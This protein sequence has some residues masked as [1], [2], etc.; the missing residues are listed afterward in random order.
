MGAAGFFVPSFLTRLP[1]LQLRKVEISGNYSVPFEE[2]KVAVEELSKNLLKL[3]E[4]E[5]ENLLNTR[6]GN[7]IREV[8]LKRSFT[9]EG[10][11]LKVAVEER[12]PVARLKL[13]NSYKLV[14]RDGVVFKP[15][16][17]EGEGL[18]EVTAYDLDLLKETFP[19]LYNEV[20][21]L[22]LPLRRVLIRKSDILL[23]LEKKR[24]LLPPARS[25]PSGISERLR[26]IYNIPQEEVD[27]RYDKF[28]LVRN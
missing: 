15:L 7:R 20:L 18:V 13:G 16:K 5:L 21:S 4:S 3:R 23:E 2:I 25:L 10:I 28:I 19:T 1:Q 22:G 11:V 9:A 12:H 26:M 6:F 14:D 27:L 8:K 17:G 24:V